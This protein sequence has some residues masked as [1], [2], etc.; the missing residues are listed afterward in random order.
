[1]KKGVTLIELIISIGMASL[2]LSFLVLQLLNYNSIGVKEAKDNR[3]YF[4]CMEA[5]MFIEYET[6]K[7][8]SVSINDDVIELKY[9]DQNIN[10]IIR[11]NTG[12][13]IVITHKEGN[14]IKAS[15]NIITDI[16]GFQAFQKGNT[17][18]ISI[19]RKNGDKYERCIGIKPDI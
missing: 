3:D 4:Y 13:K 7:A 9:V 19:T 11:L 1:M 6:D 12:G 8:K 18:Y 17:V 15:N 5:L 2:L 10:K 14:E 16:A